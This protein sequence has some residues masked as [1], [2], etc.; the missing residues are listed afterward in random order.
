MPGVRSLRSWSKVLRSLLVAALVLTIAPFAPPDAA[1]AATRLPIAK[2]RYSAGPAFVLEIRGDGSLWVSGNGG[3]AALGLGSTV[4]DVGGPTRIG[5]DT[6]W[7]YVHAGKGASFAIKSDGTLWTWGSNQNGALGLG[8]QDARYVPTQVGT[9]TDW[10]AAVSEGSNG[11]AF[12]LKSDGSLWAWGYNGYGELGLGDT[13]TRLTPARVG[14][15]NDW[16][17]ISM[18]TSHVA[19]LK[20]DGTLWTWGNNM[21][22]QI[23]QGFWS[24][25]ITT[26]SQIPG[27]WT[28]VR[29]GSGHTM[30]IRADGTL[31]GWGGNFAG[32]LGDGTTTDQYSP[33]QA[34]TAEDWVG[35]A[36]GSNHTIGIRADGSL[37]GWGYNDYGQVGDATFEDR[38]SPTPLNMGND[39]L[40]V[41][42][43]AE[44]IRS[45][46]SRADGSLWAWGYNYNGSLG[47]GGTSDV[48]VPTALGGGGGWIDI[49]EGISHSVAVRADGTLWAAGLNRYG[50]L[51]LGIANEYATVSRYQ[52]IGSDADWAAVVTSSEHVLAL[53][54]DGTLWA[55]GNNELSGLGVTLDGGATYSTIPVQV[56]ADD[57]WSKIAVGRHTSYA[58]KHDGSLWAWGW[59]RDGQAGV[60]S[61]ANIIA[62]PQVVDSDVSW[63]TVAGHFSRAM[64]IKADGTLW[65][66]GDYGSGKL[67]IEGLWEYPRAPM[68]VGE[69]ADWVSLAVGQSHSLGLKADGSLW[70]W[71]SNSSGELALGDGASSVIWTPTPLAAGLAEVDCWIAIA[72]NEDYSHA[73]AADGSL[74]AWGNN[75]YATLGD[76][77]IDHRSEPARIGARNDWVR[78]TSSWGF[79]STRGL[80]ADGSMSAW[81]FDEYGA[82]RWGDGTGPYRM[83]QSPRVV[84]G[85]KRDGLLRPVRMVA[86]HTHA[87]ALRADGTLWG[88]GGNNYGQALGASGGD[89]TRPLS[90]SDVPEW[91]DVRGGVQFTL[92]LKADGTL[93]SWGYNGQGQLGLGDTVNRATPTRIGLDSDWVSIA[94]HYN[95]GYA[96]K[97]DGT[98][99]VWGLND[100]LEP[101]GL[102][103]GA[104]MIVTTPTQVG[105]DSDW[106]K[107]GEGGIHK[108]AIKTNG[109]L[110]S[111]GNNFRGR[112]GLGDEVTRNVPEQVGIASDWVTV[113]GG[114]DQS[115]GIRANGTL[116][117]W[118]G[119]GHGQLGLSDTTNRLVPTQV[120]GS[121]WTDVAAGTFFAVGM[122]D[123][124]SLWSWGTNTQ[125]QLGLGHNSS[126][127]TPMRIGTRNDWRSISARGKAAYALS[128][129]GTV[130]S[131]GQNTNG[132]LGVGDKTDRN[133]PT[134]AFAPGDS[135]APVIFGVC[136]ASHPVPAVPYGDD[137]FVGTVKAIDTGSSVIGYSWVIDEMPATVPDESVD[138]WGADV[139]ISQSDLTPGTWYLHVRAVDAGYNVSPVFTRAIT[140]VEASNIAPVA[141][142]DSYTTEYGQLLSVNA[143]GVLANDS[144]PDG[145]DDLLIAEQLTSVMHGTLG[146]SANGAF[147]YTPDVGF[148]GVDTFTYRAYDGTDYSAAA[149][150]SITVR[151]EVLPPVIPIA[152]DNRFET[153]VKASQQAYPDGLAL[154]GKR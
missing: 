63:V 45:F 108:L 79:Y 7:A 26:P 22:G 109:T 1:E 144:D 133:V 21:V 94:T 154:D 143:P 31:W 59:N 128:A 135:I 40:S 49:A 153:A 117:A 114:E 127:N 141:V 51:G 76:G 5:T 104:D 147:T 17:A 58:I 42:A 54:T 18:G 122:R 83:F 64:G 67:G 89:V 131:W 93:W 75:N 55:W 74:W 92:G 152:G 24:V 3:A 62:A 81:G 8:D 142:N 132:Q 151:P 87:Q 56:G 53:K 69:D 78:L 72:A 41:Y 137:T 126:R 124:G 43:G 28:T 9:D 146:F 102:G 46:G 35:V 36:T 19:A 86:G 10:V 11:S 30:A 121:G 44:S 2:Q 90:V 13:D 96:I 57:D 61:S 119:N 48:N 95:G 4:N 14:T 66:W 105:T 47:T 50:C 88:W 106:A 149:T 107:V 112:L 60:D 34:G 6:D 38:H 77:T 99:W 116:W 103:D 20:A 37:W 32:Q 100:S 148:S 150:V 80:H 12:A 84:A 115:Y 70:G 71:G 33:V 145:D 85:G 120:T 129:S 16:V 82:E 136:S 68:Q 139:T 111:W 130:Y 98:L 27:R 140:V 101:L 118:G 125:G 123:D 110:W 138:S 65:G 91:V 73:I 23:G 97:A 113:V 52:Q 25:A 15:A 29:C 39:W 134:Q